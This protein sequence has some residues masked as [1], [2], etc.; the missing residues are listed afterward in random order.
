[1]SIV[2]DFDVMYGILIDYENNL[3]VFKIV[4]KVEV[5]DKENVKLV[6]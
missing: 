4:I 5:E 6:I 3:W 1:M 2:V